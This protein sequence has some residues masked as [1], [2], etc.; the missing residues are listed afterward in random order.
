MLSVFPLSDHGFREKAKQSLV[1]V[2]RG[3]VLDAAMVAAIEALLRESYPLASVS[4]R[5]SVANPGLEAFRDDDTLDVQLVLRMNAGDVTA[6]GRLYDRHAALVY[7]I[8]ARTTADR[9]LSRRATVNTFRKDIVGPCQAVIPRRGEAGSITTSRRKEQEPHLNTD[10]SRQIHALT[11]ELHDR[12]M[13]VVREFWIRAH[14][15]D[16]QRRRQECEM[17]E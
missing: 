11:R 10:L 8:V 15:R 1:S 14:A 12:R 17:C 9:D 5:E 16:D 7:S 2:A 4:R 6:A 3:Y 13:E